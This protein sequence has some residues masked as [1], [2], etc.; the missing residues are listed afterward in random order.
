MIRRRS[1]L[2]DER[3]VAAVEFALLAPFLML[4]YFGLV[5]FVQAFQA[6]KRVSH[7]AMAVADV[8]A[9]Q[10][11]VTDAQLDDAMQAGVVLM[12]PFPE[13]SLAERVA[14]LRADA[15]GTVSVDWVRTRN[16]T[17]GSAPSVPAGFLA[18]GESA[19]VTDVAYT[20]TPT[21]PLAISAPITMTRHAYVRPRLSDYVEKQ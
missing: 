15:S 19:I 14:S 20:Y 9:Q 3:G 8:A 1:L 13:A 12:T 4:L 2:K 17:G 11:V 16:W 21:F 7:V 5:E 18:A 10:R 6:Q